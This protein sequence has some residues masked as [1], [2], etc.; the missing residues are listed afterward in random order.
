MRISQMP[1]VKMKVVVDE[2]KIDVGN[3]VKLIFH[4]EDHNQEDIMFKS[5]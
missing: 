4:N 5:I 1:V 2:L 3:D